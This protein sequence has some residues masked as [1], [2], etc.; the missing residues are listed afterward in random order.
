MKRIIFIICV[1]ALFFGGCARY[2][3]DINAISLGMTKQEVI[4][5][6]GNPASI[7]ATKGVEYLNY[8]Y[9]EDDKDMWWGI[10]HPYYVQIIDGKVTAYGRHGDFGVA[11]DAQQRQKIDIQV[12]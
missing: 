5:R 6:L 8:R 3:K 1:I 10:T 7:S 11:E 4:E 12:K 2:A 9:Y